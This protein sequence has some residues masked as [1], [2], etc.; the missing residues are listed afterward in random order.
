MDMENILIIHMVFSPNN[1]VLYNKG[2][3]VGHVP[4][5]TL[6]SYIFHCYLGFEIPHTIQDVSYDM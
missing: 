5:L 1:I 2:T 6:N 4:L 3:C